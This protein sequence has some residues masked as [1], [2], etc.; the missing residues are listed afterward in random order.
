VLG[1]KVWEKRIQIDGSPT[2]LSRIDTLV[3]DD[4]TLKEEI[5]KLETRMEEGRRTLEDLNRREDEETGALE[6]KRKPIVAEFKSAD[7]TMKDM[8]KEARDLERERQRL[9]KK[10]GQ[11]EREIE[12]IREDDGRSSEEKDNHIR[13]LQLRL[14]EISDT[15]AEMEARL[16][17]I[18]SNLADQTKVCDRL[19]SQVDGIDEEM[20]SLRKEHKKRQKESEKSLDLLDKDKRAQVIK[21]VGLEK[22][23]ALLFDEL[24]KE[25][26]RLRLEDEELALIIIQ[27]DDIE[28]SIQELERKLN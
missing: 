25:A 5:E 21:R 24:G 10:A 4:K 16:V 27:I 7:D 22:E 15:A 1:Q 12:K 3:K 2:D 6:E 20:E 14:K 11:T 17:E 28:N 23:L 13:P 8:E 26:Y 19:K 18:R 9:E